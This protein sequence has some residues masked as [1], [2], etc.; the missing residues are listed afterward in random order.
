MN[1]RIISKLVHLAYALMIYPLIRLSLFLTA[2]FLPK[3]RRG[4]NERKLK[5]GIKPWLVG[6]KASRPLW[7]HCAS[8]EF[9]YAKPVITRAKLKWPDQK[10][11]VTYFSPGIASQIKKF[12]EVDLAVP[13]P[14]DTASDWNEFIDYH[15]PQALLIART[16]AWY[17]MCRSVRIRN[18]PSLLFSATLT[19]KSGRRRRGIRWLTKATFSN[20]SQVQ[21]VS[22]DDQQ[23]FLSLGLSSKN[24]SVVGDTRYDQTIERLRKPKLLPAGLSKYDWATT[25]VAG[26]TW[27]EDEAVLIPAIKFLRQQEP[28]IT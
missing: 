15:Q 2:P 28:S 27:V 11:I 1:S 26:S 22:S 24:I 21:C 4:L 5:N 23:A 13:M 20:L 10:I 14:W 25:L 17:E 16:D 7:F 8:G 6:A 9:E 19:E 18:I 3:I 12:S